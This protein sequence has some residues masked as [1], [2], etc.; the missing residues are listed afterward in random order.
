MTTMHPHWQ[1][2]DADERPV[3]ITTPA[4]TAAKPQA[5]ITPRASRR[6]AAL[7]GIALFALI[8]F[9][10][11]QGISGIQAQVSSANAV[12]HITENGA[13]PDTVTVQPGQSIGWQND[14]AIPQV[15]FSSTLLG[16]D[17]KP[18]ETSPIFPGS[19]DTF[20]I[21]ANIQPGTYDYSSKT[22]QAVN[23]HIVIEGNAQPV[24][25]T[26]PTQTVPEAMPTQDSPSMAQTVTP[27][28]APSLIPQ[29]T[30]TVGSNDMPVTQITN[31][32]PY[33]QP[34][35]GMGTWVTVFLSIL[36]IL[37]VSRKHFRF[38]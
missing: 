36:A 15:L 33:S 26:Q 13:S 16:S 2:T 34:E 23:G 20:T 4:K 18:F 9:G 8:G 27:S 37:F 1:S 14:S 21:P 28:A 5:S 3:K 6:P 24:A 29:N 35:S 38:A 31:H 22:S 32:T 30:H 12:V 25:A 7:A 17:G 11:M 19:A 10:I